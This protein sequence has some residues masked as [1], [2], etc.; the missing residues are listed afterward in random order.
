MLSKTDS[1]RLAETH[2]ANNYHPLDVVIAHGEGIW[3]TDTQQKRYIDMLSAYSALN[4]GHRHPKIIEAMKTQL[5]KVTLTSRAFH[6]D[7]FG[8]FARELCELCDPKGSRNLQI[9]PMNSGAEAVE[10]AIKTARKWGT[11]VKNVPKETA[12]IIVCSNNFHGRTITLISFSTEAQ[13]R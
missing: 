11:V 2:S 13:Y 3:V 9:L 8:L 7:Q 10:T 4:Q 6:N 5:D 12:N 1:I